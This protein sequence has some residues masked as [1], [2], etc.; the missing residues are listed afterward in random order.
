MIL[1][2]GSDLVPISDAAQPNPYA[3]MDQVHAEYCAMLRNMDHTLD[4][5]LDDLHYIQQKIDQLNDHEVRI[6]HPEREA[7]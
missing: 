7:L 6:Q 1:G 3:H 5:I 2:Q 4:F